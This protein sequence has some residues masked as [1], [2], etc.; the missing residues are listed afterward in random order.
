MKKRL[1][2]IPR[3]EKKVL[4]GKEI[5]YYSSRHKRRKEANERLSS[6]HDGGG[7]S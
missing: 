7:T 5:D 6:L 2:S 3:E 4:G 1:L